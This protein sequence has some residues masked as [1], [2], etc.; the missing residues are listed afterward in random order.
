MRNCPE[1]IAN[2]LL[3]SGSQDKLS[4][5]NFI[6]AKT[7]LLAGIET[8]GHWPWPSRSFWPFWLR[9]LANLACPSISC[10]GFELE[11]PNLHQI[12]NLGYSQL[13]LKMGLIDLDLQGYLAIS[14]QETAFNVTVVYWS[15][16]AKGC[17]TSQTCSFLICCRH[18][19]RY[20]NWI[21]GKPLSSWIYFEKQKICVLVLV[22]F[23][24]LR[25]HRWLK[26]YLVEDKGPFIQNTCI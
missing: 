3:I 2:V 4:W 13:L 18:E 21:R 17:Y 22:H 25:C 8:G 24:S 9:I 12:R 10:G 19:S 5:R 23:L 7:L 20:I 1:E 26:S 15:R 11:S 14:S 16:L 6:L